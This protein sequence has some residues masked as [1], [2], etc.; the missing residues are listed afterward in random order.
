[1]PITMFYAGLLALVLLALSVRTIQARAATKVY[2]G[3]GGNELML[4]R[5]RGMANFVEYVPLILIMLALLELRA[6]APWQLHALGAT[7]L[8]ARVLHGYT[9]AFATHFPAGRFLGAVLTQA[10]LAVSALLCVWKGLAG[11]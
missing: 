11:L 5:M 8:V 2:M 6:T 7:L 3:D 4:R 1:M 10:A 9:F